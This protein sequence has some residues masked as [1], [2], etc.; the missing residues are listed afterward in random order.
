MGR[1]GAGRWEVEG[2]TGLKCSHVL[3]A[4]MVLASV[5]NALE[6][7]WGGTEG[8]ETGFCEEPKARAHDMSQVEST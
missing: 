4:F 2:S 1:V 8:L 5:L 3:E 6:G 7:V